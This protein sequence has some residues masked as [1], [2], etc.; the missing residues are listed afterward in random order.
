MVRAQRHGRRVNLAPLTQHIFDESSSGSEAEVETLIATPTEVILP[1]VEDSSDNRS[2]IEEQP[3]GTLSPAQH[4]R[5]REWIR[6][7]ALVNHLPDLLVSV[8][9]DKSPL[10]EDL[11]SC[12]ILGIVDKPMPEF[13]SLTSMMH[14]FSGPQRVH[15]DVPS[16]LINELHCQLVIACLA[17]HGDEATTR[18]IS[19]H[20]IT[21]LKYILDATPARRAAFRNAHQ[22]EKFQDR[23][24]LWVKSR[25]SQKEVLL[26]SAIR[27]HK[28]SRFGDFEIV[29]STSFIEE[30][31]SGADEVSGLKDIAT[32]DEL[33]NLAQLPQSDLNKIYGHLN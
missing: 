5:I 32:L 3:S 29:P 4:D 7:F 6:E 18:L 27:A 33:I 16:Q 26:S 14:I 20:G 2:H 25:R 1:L 24:R 8:N 21:N 22:W 12:T 9:P 19:M 31:V 28:R 15:D 23:L 13:S 17:E 10:N 11:L 30:S